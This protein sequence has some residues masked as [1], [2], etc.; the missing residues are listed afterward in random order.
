MQVFIKKKNKPY[1]EGIKGKGGKRVCS[2]KRCKNQVQ[3]GQTHKRSTMRINRLIVYLGTL[4]MTKSTVAASGAVF[5][6]G[7]AAMTF[8]SDSAAR[9]SHSI[10]H[11]GNGDLVEYCCLRS[12]P[13]CFKFV[14]RLLL[15][16][17]VLLS[18][19]RLCGLS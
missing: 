15:V 5:R 13:V 17:C 1:A 3:F 7:A 4:D 12:A 16:N 11:G 9:C 8:G 18:A 2:E 14:A 10:L 19:L 6:Q